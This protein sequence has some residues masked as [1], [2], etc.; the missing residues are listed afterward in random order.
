MVADMS[1]LR[2]SRSSWVFMILF[3]ISCVTVYLRRWD[4]LEQSNWTDERIQLVASCIGGV[5]GE[6]CARCS[7]N[8]V[9]EGI[10]IGRAENFVT[11]F[12]E[13]HV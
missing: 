5:V 8:R 4:G 2:G 6:R 3:E 7:G 11:C 1:L 13:V 9:V 12:R 10:I